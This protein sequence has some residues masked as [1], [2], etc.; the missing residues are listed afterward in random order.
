VT[1]PLRIAYKA[2]RRSKH[3]QHQ[4][5]AVVVR[6][7]AVVS[8]AVNGPPGRGHAE[9]RALRPHQDYA[10]CDLYVVR[11]R[12]RKTSRPCQRCLT[13]IVAS[14]IRRVT[15]TDERGSECTENPLDIYADI[16]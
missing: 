3:P 6:G 5:A 15:F 14:G 9:A 7:G 13:K 16:W 8:V 2:A 4:L 11:L 12:G 10:G 1:F